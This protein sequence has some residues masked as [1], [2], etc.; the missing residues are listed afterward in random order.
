MEQ[1]QIAELFY[2]ALVGL[3]SVQELARFLSPTV[4]WILS[5]ADPNTVGDE[6]PPHS[7]KFAGKGS[8]RQLALYFRENLKVFSGYLTGCV[9]RHQLVFVLGEVRLRALA[10]DQLA[11]TRV[12]ARLTFYHSEIIKGQIRILW[13]L[14]YAG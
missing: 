14:V 11:E 5:T 8:F 1:V 3:N 4:Q 6:S 7:L 9:S 12:A 2:K 10:T 13:P